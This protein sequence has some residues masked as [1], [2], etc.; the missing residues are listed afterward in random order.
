MREVV[1]A[2]LRH[3]KDFN[4][5]SELD[6]W[7]DEIVSGLSGLSGLVSRGPADGTKRKDGNRADGRGRGGRR[8]AVSLDVDVSPALL[9][10]GLHGH[11]HQ[12]GVVPHRCFEHSLP[13]LGG[14]DHFAVADVDGDVVD[15]GLDR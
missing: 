1:N 3:R 13:G 8:L 14:F 12:F 10:D 7:Y 2:V 4:V 11:R 15:R 5:P 6:G 9:G